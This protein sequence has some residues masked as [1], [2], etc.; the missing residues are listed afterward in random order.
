[1]ERLGA[2]FVST[3]APA[4]AIAPGESLHFAVPLPGLTAGKHGV[5]ARIDLAGDEARANDSDSILFRVGP[6]P[7]E[8]TEI[9]F[10]PRAG[11]GEWVEVA[12]RSGVPIDLDAFALSDRTGAAAPP[13]PRESAGPLEPDSLAVLAQHRNDLLLRYPGIDAQ[14]VWEVAPW[15]ALNNSNDASGI[16]DAV[17]V[18]DADGVLSD[19]VDYSSAG[20]PDGVPIEKRRGG[21]WPALQAAGSPLLPPLTPPPLRG[22]FQLTPRRIATARQSVSIQWDV[23]WPRATASLSVYDLAGRLVARPFEGVQIPARGQRNWSPAA[24]RAGVYILALEIEPADRTERLV[25]TQPLR[26]VSNA[27]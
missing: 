15:S 19:R 10:H 13:R 14:R 22:H 4:R 21:W 11:E 5:I 8:V 26:I 16:A 18:R 6:G 3:P 7:I 23:I 20:V 2:A 12:N 9:Q 27:P 24:L 25:A 1:V 17:V